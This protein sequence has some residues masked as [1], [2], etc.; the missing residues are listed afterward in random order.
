MIA[1]AKTSGQKEFKNCIAVDKKGGVD[2]YLYSTDECRY[3]TITLE[4]FLELSDGEL[5]KPSQCSR[6]NLLIRSFKRNNEER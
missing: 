2:I 3:K 6:L 4:Q 1:I 5:M